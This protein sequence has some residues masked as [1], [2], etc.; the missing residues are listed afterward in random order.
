LPKRVGGDDPTENN[1]RV[2]EAKKRLEKE[3]GEARKKDQGVW[4]KKAETRQGA[5]GSGGFM[6]QGK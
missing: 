2:S 6:G 1:F 5:K 4:K 3:G